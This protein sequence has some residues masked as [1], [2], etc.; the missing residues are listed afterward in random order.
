VDGEIVHEFKLD[1]LR[2]TAASLAI[3]AAANI[4]ARQNMLGHES[5]R[6][7]LDR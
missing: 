5:A 4:S 3:Q 7:T 1:K 2:H 6:L